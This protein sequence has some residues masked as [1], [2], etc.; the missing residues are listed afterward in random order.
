MPTP[1]S[2]EIK[3]A[4]FHFLGNPNGRLV[5]CNISNVI[6]KKTAE[7]HLIIGKT[8]D[9]GKCCRTLFTEIQQSDWLVAVV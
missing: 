7:G 8:L 4:F 6:N 9:I 5:S 2:I 1:D 3:T